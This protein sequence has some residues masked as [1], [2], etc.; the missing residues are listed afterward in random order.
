LNPEVQDYN[1][2]RLRNAYKPTLTSTVFTRSQVQ[3]PTNQ[4]NGGNIVTNEN[5]TYNAGIGQSLPGAAATS[6]S[7]GTIRSRR[8]TTRSPTST[9]L[10]TRT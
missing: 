8:R 4:L 1:L 9:R 5:A 7:P 6:A 3:P 2:A 10:T